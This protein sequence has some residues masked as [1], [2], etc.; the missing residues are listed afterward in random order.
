MTSDVP[1]APSGLSASVSGRSVTLR[2]TDNSNNES[3][4]YIERALSPKKGSPTWSRIGQV[5]SNVA[6]YTDNLSAAGTY[7]YRVQAFTA[8]KVSSYSN[9]VSV[10]VR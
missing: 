3:G 5:G 8:T 6:I 10:R 7:L 4:F 9:Q 2:W 1:N